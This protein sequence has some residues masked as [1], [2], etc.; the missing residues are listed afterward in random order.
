MIMHKGKFSSIYSAQ[1]DRFKFCV[2]SKNRYKICEQLLKGGCRFAAFRPYLH[3]TGFGIVPLPKKWEFFSA[4]LFYRLSSPNA[5]YS[6]SS[7]KN[8][9]GLISRVP[10]M[11]ILTIIVFIRH[12]STFQNF[13]YSKCTHILAHCTSFV[14]L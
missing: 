3:Y 1:R 4:L 10:H 6:N 7:H 13:L 12:Y 14:T 11:C 9:I 5:H 8:L 2:N